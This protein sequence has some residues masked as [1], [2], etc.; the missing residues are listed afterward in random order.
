VKRFPEKTRRKP[1]DPESVE[2]FSEQDHAQSRMIWKNG[3]RF[4][5]QDHAQN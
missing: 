2:R 5:E 4:S 1:H 3:K